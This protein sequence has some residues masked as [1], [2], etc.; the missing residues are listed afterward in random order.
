[1]KYV[2]I[3]IVLVINYEYKNSHLDSVNVL[4]IL[5]I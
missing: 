3:V 4:K 1:M 2:L 5:L